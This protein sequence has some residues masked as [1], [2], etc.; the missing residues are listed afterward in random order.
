LLPVLNFIIGVVLIMFLGYIS[1]RNVINEK[2]ILEYKSI[3]DL[4]RKKISEMLNIRNFDKIKIKEKSE[5]L[6]NELFLKLFSY[7][8][9][10]IPVSSSDSFLMRLYQW[11]NYFLILKENLFILFFGTGLYGS[12][13][14]SG[15]KGYAID[16]FYV[17]VLVYNG[18]IGLLIVMVILYKVWNFIFTEALYLKNNFLKPFLIIFPTFFLVSFFDEQFLPVYLTYIILSYFLNNAKNEIA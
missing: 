9:K 2:S 18:I 3:V 5:D 13:Y 8:I 1:S 10:D 14:L 4:N 16:N 11:K 7:K 6:S 15:L 12:R 17:H